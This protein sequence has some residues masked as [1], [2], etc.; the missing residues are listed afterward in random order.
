MKLKIIKTEA[1]NI[2]TKIIMNLFIDLIDKLIS[3]KFLEYRHEEN[4]DDEKYKIKI[5]NN[6]N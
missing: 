5:Y 4:I 6:N 1:C 3:F 2:M